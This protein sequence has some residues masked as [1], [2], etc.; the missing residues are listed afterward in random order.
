[1]QQEDSCGSISQRYISS[2]PDTRSIDDVTCPSY[3]FKVVLHNNV[4]S[5]SDASFVIGSITV[6]H[7]DG[8]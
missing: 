2:V 3:E 4:F 8:Q 7:S 5:D 1:M 6:M